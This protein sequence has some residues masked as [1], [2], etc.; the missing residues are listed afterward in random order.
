MHTIKFKL[1]AILS[2]LAVAIVV[3]GVAAWSIAHVTIAGLSS[4]YLDRVVPLRDLKDTSDAYAVS[5][6]DG[7]HKMRSGA[8]GLAE[9]G[10]AIDSALAT[11]GQRYGAYM[12]TKMDERELALAKAAQKT[13]ADAEPKIAELRALVARGDRAGLERFVETTLYPTIDPITGAIE[14][15][16]GLQLV[17]AKNSYESADAASSQAMIVLWSIAAASMVAV[18]IGYYVV[19]GGVI[20]PLGRITA[21]MTRIAEGALDTEV[22]FAGTRNE[23][24]EMAA[25]VEVFKRNGVER[26]ALEAAQ[27]E[28]RAA[29]EHRATAVEQLIGAFDAV[30][31]RIIGAVASA[32]TELQ[33]AA[34][35]LNGTAEETSNQSSAV[36]AAAEESASNVQTVAASSE[37]MAASIGEIGRRVEEAARVST[38]AVAEAQDTMASVRELATAAQRIGDIVGLI[39]DVAGQTNLLALNATI[40]AARAGEAGRGFAVV[41]SEVKGLAEQTAKASAQIAQQIGG[42]QTSTGRAVEAIGRIAGTIERISAISAG[43]ATSVEHQTVATREISQS[44][45][46]VSAGTSEVTSNMVGV[47]RAAEETSAAAGQVHSASSELATQAARLRTEVDRFLAD[48]RAA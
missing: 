2:V 24:G 5:I 45:Q 32:A 47:T 26:V 44:V 11:A 30:T 13:M 18:G 31:S 42:I 22:P 16:V 1:L 9:G 14:K 43:I 15:L 25:A 3:S 41:A 39:G 48:V 6:V 33:A 10:R 20:R 46:Q 27:A 7:A 17:E 35:T 28:E 23:V 34:Q 19:L 8:L 40:E 37:E 21:V 4:V 38:S 12:Q 29:R 36:S